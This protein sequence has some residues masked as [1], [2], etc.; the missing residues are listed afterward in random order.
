MIAMGKQTQAPP[1]KYQ[2]RELK[3]S[4]GFVLREH[5]LRRGKFD[6]MA[7]PDNHIVFHVSN[8]PDLIVLLQYAAAGPLGRMALDMEEGNA[9]STADRMAADPL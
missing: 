4:G 9:S 3:R 1:P 8:I 5:T 7:H 6:I 2:E